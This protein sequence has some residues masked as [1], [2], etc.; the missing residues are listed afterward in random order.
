MS[1]DF[2][3]GGGLFLAL[4]C[5]SGGVQYRWDCGSWPGEA[6]EWLTSFSSFFALP[7]SFFEFPPLAGGIAAAR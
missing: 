7:A 1:L 3:G 6:V 5:A 4:Q 2:G